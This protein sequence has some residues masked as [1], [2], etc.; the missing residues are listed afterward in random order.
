MLQHLVIP[1]LL[2]LVLTIWA[3]SPHNP[4]AKLPQKIGQ[5]VGDITG[6][7]SCKGTEAGGK[8]YS[9]MAVIQKKNDVYIVHWMVGGAGFTGVGI[10][11]G[12]TISVSWALPG[13]KGIVRGV[14]VYRIEQGPR[15]IGRWASLPGPGIVQDET[16][17]FLKRLEPDD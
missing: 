6:F 10:R 7:Y 15:L 12:D 16:L 4:P 9:G 11:L 8:A 5:E 17:V 13:E 2:A 1:P 3:A 14:N